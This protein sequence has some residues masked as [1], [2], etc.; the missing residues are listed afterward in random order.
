MVEKHKNKSEDG[1]KRSSGWCLRRD[2][3]ETGDGQAMRFVYTVR[4]SLQIKRKS[5]SVGSGGLVWVWKR[6]VETVGKRACWRLKTRKYEVS[7][8]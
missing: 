4:N 1:S 5:A 2:E 3:R 8:R 7:A 6:Q